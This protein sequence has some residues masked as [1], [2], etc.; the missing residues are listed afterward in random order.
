MKLSRKFVSDYIDLDEKLSIKEIAEAMTG[1]GN[2]YD[3]ASS[4]IN[5]TNLTVGEV[6]ECSD[7]PD[8]DHLHVCKVNVGEEI[9]DIVCG[10]PNVRVGLKVI[11][12][13]PGAILPGGEIKKGKIRGVE[14]N[15]MLC[16]KA[17]LGLDNKFLD[18][19]DNYDIIYVDDKDLY[20]K[21]NDKK[22]ILK[23]PRVNEYLKELN[24]KLLV[25]E[26]GCVYKY[27][28]VDTDFSLNV[29]NS[30]AVAF[31][32]SIGV[33]KITLSY[34]LNYKQIKMLVDSYKT[35]YK[36]HPNLEVLTDAFE[37]VMVCKYNILKKYNKKEGY[38]LDRFNNKYKVVNKDNL[39][40]IY[41]YNKRNL[42]DD[43]YSIGINYVRK[44]I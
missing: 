32:H 44:N 6:I 40:Y 8:S 10:A 26:L 31:L 43:Y 27:K 42:K 28:N 4:L 19:K 3:D 5:C 38:L 14:S 33:N 12:A 22:C 24:N 34:E 39:M 7:H 2:E 21:I 37:E 20:D 1:V 35:R 13:L 29:F 15:G 23:L 16:S 11:V 36:K 41:N 17:E 30:Y 25:G 9:L 18:E